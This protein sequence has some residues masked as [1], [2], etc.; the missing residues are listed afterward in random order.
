MGS[1]QPPTTYLPQS[2][3]FLRTMARHYIL[4]PRAS[5]SAI[6]MEPSGGLVEMTI[7]L[8]VADTI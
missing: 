8:K 5:I 2:Y 3:E 1:L 6:R 4:D 7:T